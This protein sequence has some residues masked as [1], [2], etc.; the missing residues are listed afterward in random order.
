MT[1]AVIMPMENALS[2]IAGIDQLSAQVNAGGSATIT[3]RFVLERDINDAS[4]DVREKVAGVRPLF[5]D[6]VKSPERGPLT[7]V[8]LPHGVR[9]QHAAGAGLRQTPRQPPLQ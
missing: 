5:R 2:G 1:S 8:P 7:P 6:E 4:N 9:F 3:V